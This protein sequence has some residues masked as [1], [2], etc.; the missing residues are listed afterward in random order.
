MKQLR[1]DFSDYSAQEQEMD[2][3][4]AERRKYTDV[5]MSKVDGVWHAL[6]PNDLDII[7]N[8]KNGEDLPKFYERLVCKLNKDF[9]IKPHFRNIQNTGV[10]EYIRNSNAILRRFNNGR[11]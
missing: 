10:D 7:I 3:L 2:A 9:K 8:G 4:R 1:L 11:D 5:Y 6:I